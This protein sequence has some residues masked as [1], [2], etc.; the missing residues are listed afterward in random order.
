M[1][2]FVTGRA[3][4]QA[5]VGPRLGMN[6][7]ECF[8]QYRS[9]D[10]AAIFG[11]SPSSTIHSLGFKRHRSMRVASTKVNFIAASIYVISGICQP[12]LMTK[13]KK[14]GLADS[15]A[16]L[17]MLFYYAGPSLLLIRVF[18]E[19]KNGDID[20]ESLGPS[21]A[22]VLKACAI[23]LL[24]TLAQSL[25]YTGAGMTGATIFSVIYSSVTVWT[26]VYARV[27]LGRRLSTMQWV[28]IA[29]VFLGLCI[30]ARSS[31][32][33]GRGIVIGTA[34]TLLGSSLHGGTYVMSEF[35]MTQKQRIQSSTCHRRQ[36]LL[37]HENS[38]IQ[39]LVAFSGFLSWQIF[40]TLPRWAELIDDPMKAAG[41][42]RTEA[43][44]V[45]LAFAGANLFHSYSFYYTLAN[46][47]GGSTSA[48][49][50]KGLQAAL[51]FILAHW[52]FCDADNPGMC[53]SIS[54]LFSLIIV[55]T[56][57]VLYSWGKP[58]PA[59][60]S[61][62]LIARVQQRPYGAVRTNDQVSNQHV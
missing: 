57:V 52:I 16:Q 46:Y 26:A 35:I 51:V 60:T 29:I 2:P 20:G 12:L 62:L 5:H 6:L 42:G 59:A 21:V 19:R 10:T 58:L 40:Y 53:F 36:Y 3:I 45:L 43:L 34:L 27:F 30:T 37:P 33:L 50:L 4:F 25:N 9:K 23:A 55:G 47:P 8:V 24:D 17:Y 44:L 1:T 13:C 7:Q 56:G 15:S 39:A 54:K 61:L 48:G 41:T 49:V 38:A 32:S 22:V 14:S 18:Y 31:A 11:S 28:A